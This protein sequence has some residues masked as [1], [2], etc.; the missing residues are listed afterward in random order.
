MSIH[1]ALAAIYAEKMVTPKMEAFLSQVV[2]SRQLTHAERRSLR[3]LM[4]KIVSGE[5]LLLSAL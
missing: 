5:I 2:Q 4:Y 1:A 3:E